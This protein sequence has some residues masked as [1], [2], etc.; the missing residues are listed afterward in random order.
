MSVLSFFHV[1]ELSNKNKLNQ[2]TGQLDNGH[3]LIYRMLIISFLTVLFLNLYVNYT[4]RSLF[5][6]LGSDLEV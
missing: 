2:N 3:P 4:I 5:S 6:T 1:R